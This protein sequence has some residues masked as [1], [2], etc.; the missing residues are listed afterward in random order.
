MSNIS[1]R[2]FKYDMISKSIKS[3]KN[4]KNN[5]SKNKIKNTLPLPEWNNCINDL[6]KYKLSSAEVVN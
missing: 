6:D 5:S 2:N 4:R 3:A 1:Q